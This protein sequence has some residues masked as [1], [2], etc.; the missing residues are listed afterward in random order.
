MAE[1]PHGD[2]A[3]FCLA[4]PRMSYVLAAFPVS[5]PAKLGSGWSRAPLI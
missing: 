5:L 4:A 2:V 3:R 1:M